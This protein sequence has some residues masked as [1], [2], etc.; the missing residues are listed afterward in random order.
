MELTILMRYPVSI[1]WNFVFPTIV[2]LTLG[3]FFSS[4]NV[5]TEYNL[6]FHGE[7]GVYE[8]L[9]SLPSPELKTG[10]EVNI[11]HYKDISESQKSG[12]FDGVL[13]YCGNT[14]TLDVGSNNSQNTPFLFS[15]IKNIV[16]LVEKGPLNVFQVELS[17]S[18]Q[19][20]RDNYIFFLLPGVIAV[21]LMSVSLFS[22]GIA[23]AGYREQKILKRFAC[24]PLKK[25]EF[26]IAIVLARS[27]IILMQSAW[28]I[29]LGYIAFSVTIQSP[30]LPLAVILVLGIFAFSGI[31]VMVGSLAKKIESAS[32]IGNMLFFPMIFLSGPYIPSE[33][34]PDFLVPFTKIFPLTHFVEP[35]RAIFLGEKG[36]S[37][38]LPQIAVLLFWFLLSIFISKKYFKWDVET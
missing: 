21:S 10:Y 29:F 20:A 23:I 36:L 3:L 9:L 2:L 17:Q 32:A 16:Y 4:D 24:S 33:F 12:F 18:P 13:S 38:F 37:S 1:F 7:R 31:G 6:V 14:F 35:F 5:Q 22:I 11:I 15:H 34:I 25:S 26:L 27:V 8:Y 30:I 19:T 28:L